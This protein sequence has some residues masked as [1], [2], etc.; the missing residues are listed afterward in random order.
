[1]GLVGTVAQIFFPHKPK[2]V[3][4]AGNWDPSEHKPWS[5]RLQQKI[6]SSP[7]LTHN[8]KVLVYGEW[9]GQPEHIIPFFTATYS[10]KDIYEIPAKSLRPPLRALFVGALL[11]GKRPLTAIRAVEELL[12]RGVDIRLDLYGDGPMREQLENYVR[13]HQLGDHVIFHGKRSAAE[14]KEAYQK[15]HFLIFPSRSE[16]WPKVVAEAMLW[17]CLPI[18]TPVSAVPYMLGNGSRGSLVDAD[19]VQIA[20]EVEYYLQHPDEYRQKT[21]EGFRW[22]KQF[23]L[24]KF[25]EEIAKL[26]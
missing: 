15:A 12:K 10:E 4:Y 13:E 5:Y 24:E 6:I 22:S 11:E 1:M 26:L 8:A 14:V 3:K 16:G 23:T 18:T 2:T 20:D 7:L 19:P 17:K 9:P 21:E 25:E